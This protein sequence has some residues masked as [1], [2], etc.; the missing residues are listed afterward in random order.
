MVF[1]VYGSTVIMKRSLSSASSA[2]SFSSSG[3]SEDTYPLIHVRTI[4]DRLTVRDRDGIAHTKTP[5]REAVVGQRLPDIRVRGVLDDG[6]SVSG[7][8][9][10]V[11]LICN[12]TA[13]ADQ[14]CIDR[15]GTAT[16]YE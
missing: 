14:P 16:D 8:A 5:P 7:A 9:I 13:N 4:P 12:D 11:H 3:W 2:S 1:N 15:F 10:A 6:S